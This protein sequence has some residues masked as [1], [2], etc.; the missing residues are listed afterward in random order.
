MRSTSFHPNVFW[1]YKKSSYAKIVPLDY[2]LQ[3]C[4]PKASLLS[5]KCHS[6]RSSRFSSILSPRRYL[7]ASTN[8][9]ALV[10]SNFQLCNPFTLQYSSYVVTSI[11]LSKTISLYYSLNIRH[12]FSHLYNYGQNWSYTCLNMSNLVGRVV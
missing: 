11:L 6:H 8:Y 3:F 1:I 2:F 9:E 4:S 10:D 12:Q 5:H 7:V